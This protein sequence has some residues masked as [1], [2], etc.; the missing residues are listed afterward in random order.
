MS[1]EPVALSTVRN[2]LM[3]YFVIY[4]SDNAPTQCKLYGSGIGG[5][6]LKWIDS[7][8]LIATCGGKCI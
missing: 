3:S 1:Q 7:F 4:G 6:I 8:S 5:K 2:E